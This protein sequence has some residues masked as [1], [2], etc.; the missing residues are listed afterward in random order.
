MSNSNL[1][2]TCYSEYQ[3]ERILDCRGEE[4]PDGRIQVYFLIKWEDYP[5]EENTWEIFESLNDGCYHLVVKLYKKL[6]NKARKVCKKRE[7]SLIVQN[8]KE[9]EKLFHH[10]FNEMN[11]TPVFIKRNNMTIIKKKLDKISSPKVS[12]EDLQQEMSKNS[13]PY[14]S[15][16]K[17]V[18]FPITG[19]GESIKNFEEKKQ[20]DNFMEDILKKKNIYLNEFLS[21]KNNLESSNYETS[22][23]NGQINTRTNSDPFL[24]QKSIEVKSQVFPPQYDLHEAKK[25]LG[26][27]SPIF[28]KNYIPSKK[29]KVNFENFKNHGNKSNLKKIK[30]SS[31]T[32]SIGFRKTS[33]ID[34]WKK[35][36]KNQ[37]L[38]DKNRQSLI[39]D[40][41]KPKKETIKKS[42]SFTKK[43]LV[44]IEKALHW[45]EESIKLDFKT[46]KVITL[47][48]RCESSGEIEFRR[49]ESDLSVEFEKNP[50]KILELMKKSYIKKISKIRRI[51]YS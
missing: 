13:T 35:G 44:S 49:N 8:F 48:K 23:S 31:T 7:T 29:R 6:W 34:K 24:K 22:S 17:E 9:K 28:R 30:G 46:M 3:V 14:S 12:A 36:N 40:Y 38:T 2:L 25:G 11:I 18:E 42:S 20:W 10:C 51:I 26:S 1:A 50:K 47:G 5:T 4:L 43:D 16:E 21:S 45:K 32:T 27:L 19:G 15:E 39:S 33:K 41:I 37:N